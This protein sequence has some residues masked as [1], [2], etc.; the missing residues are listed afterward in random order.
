LAEGHFLFD[1]PQTDTALEASWEQYQAIVLPDLRPIGDALAARLDDWVAAGGTLIAVGQS[2]FLDEEG[3]R[4]AAP[5]L[6]CLGI[7][8]VEIVREDM[9]SSYLKLDDKSGFTRFPVTDLVYLDGPYV[10]ARFAPE[11]EQRFKLIPP[12]NYGPPERCYYELIVD[13]PGLIV[14]PYGQGKAIYVPWLPGQLYRRQGHTNTFDF[15]CDLLQGV[16][17]VAPVG[18]NLSP[19]VEVTLHESRDGKTQLL[20]LVN[21]SG[22]FGTTFFEPVPMHDVRVSIACDAAPASVASLVTGAVV[23]FEFSAGTLSVTVPRLD[24][25]EALQIT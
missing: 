9:R 3:E 19:M 8:R 23:P 6:K 22:H 16:A 20:H 24:L 2:G 11:A 25:W 18:G 12:H 1:T 7:E 21:G 17:G 15:A 13:R 10:Y 4:R 5:A 14:H